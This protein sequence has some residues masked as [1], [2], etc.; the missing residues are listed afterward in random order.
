MPEQSFMPSLANGHVGFDVY[1][2][3]IFMNGLYNGPHGNSHRARIPNFSNLRTINCDQNTLEWNCTYHMNLKTGTFEAVIENQLYKITQKIYAHRYYNRAI[4]N[5]IVVDRL[6]PAGPEYQVPLNL[7]IGEVTTDLFTERE[8][9]RVILNGQRTVK[10]IFYTTRVVE[11]I[12]YQYAPTKAYVAYTI[13]PGSLIL[14]ENAWSVEHFHIATVSGNEEEAFLELNMLVQNN[15]II[16][17]THEA[18]W[19]KF[20]DNFEI[21][22]EGDSNLVRRNFHIKIHLL[23]ILV[24]RTKFYMPACFIWRPICLL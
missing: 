24:F 7:D 6:T 22:V 21:S 12:E 1:G 11:D 14:R 23:E 18:E 8:N 19:K 10:Q 13:Q 2:D 4:I 17:S 3:S 15:T 16:S 5:H 20:W 9:T